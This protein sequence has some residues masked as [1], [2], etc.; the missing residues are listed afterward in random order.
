L[1]LDL[2]FK[3]LKDLK[4]GKTVKTHEYD[5]KNSKPIFD[6]LTIKPSKIIIV[7]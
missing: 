4:S 2:F 1:D 6:K 7:E 5:F 3:N